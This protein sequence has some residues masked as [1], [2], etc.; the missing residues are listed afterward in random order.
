MAS[1]PV[2][3]NQS[4]SAK[5]APEQHVVVFQLADE[6]YA[7]DIHAVQEIVRM[8]PITKVPGVESWVEGITNLRGRVVPV[9]DM[10][11]RCGLPVHAYTA[12]TRIVVVSGGSELGSTE[13]VGLIVDAVTEVMRIPSEQ[14]EPPGIIVKDQQ[15]AIVRGIAKLPDRLVSVIDLEGVLPGNERLSEFEPQGIRQAEAA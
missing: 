8:Q 10:R 1:R 3:P 6:L 2:D 12:D 7:L 14:I 5:I 13:M 4:E 11:E 15:K 9:L